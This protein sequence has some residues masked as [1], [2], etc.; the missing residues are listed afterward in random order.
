MQDIVNIIRQKPKIAAVVFLSF[1]FAVTILSVFLYPVLNTKYTGEPRHDMVRSAVRMNTASTANQNVPYDGDT[2]PDGN[3]KEVKGISEPD[4][5]IQEY[6]KRDKPGQKGFFAK[7]R[8][9]SSRA[10]TSSKSLLRQTSKAFADLPKYIVS[11]LKSLS[12]QQR[13]LAALAVVFV[14]FVSLNSFSLV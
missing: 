1:L 5:K 11:S 2:D 3:E 10:L 14:F 7:V 8:S 9:F 12:W 6:V 4:T 13:G